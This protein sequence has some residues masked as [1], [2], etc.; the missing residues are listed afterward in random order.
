MA[1]FSKEELLKIAE[2]SSLHLENHEVEWLRE[3]L[4]KT[5]DYTMQLD[6][7][8]SREEHDA[9]KNINVFRE[10]KVIKQDSSKLIKQAPESKNTYFVVPKNKK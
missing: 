9:V 1:N 3:Q 10:D 4:L 7:F 6:K 5:I 2:I 8:E